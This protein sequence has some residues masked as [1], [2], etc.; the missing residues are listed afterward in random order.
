MEG[1]TRTIGIQH[2]IKQRKVGDEVIKGQPTKVAVL[3]DGNLQTYLLE[4][5]RAELDWVW[6]M[7]PVKM[8]NIEADDK[9]SDFN[10]HQ[11]KFRKLK[12]DENPENFP[13]DHLHKEGKDFFL[14]T[15]VP[16]KFD[17]LMTGDKVA[18]VL[19]GS[20]NRFAGALANR[21]KEIDA[22]VWRVPPFDLKAR[23]NG[24][25]KED[26]SVVLVNLL[27]DEP[28]L[29]QKTENREIALILLR[30]RYIARIDA[31]KERIACEQR[32]WQRLNG[33]IFLSEEG[34]YPEGGME[35]IFAEMKANDAI[36]QALI[37]EEKAR[38]REL[39]KAVEATEVYQKIFLPTQRRKRFFSGNQS[40]GK[41]RRSYDWR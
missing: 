32:L 18:M 30:E 29:F 19:G 35:N 15:K 13:S 5:E 38:E 39:V 7:F 26:D 11:V 34:Q 3:N 6:G 4:D 25:S 2:R 12:K 22:E 28:T 8:R 23:R 41:I 40:S 9:L 27:K 14:A 33:Q 31:M 37:K 21:G 17:G 24:K 10:L 1:T 36:L 20:G 16:E